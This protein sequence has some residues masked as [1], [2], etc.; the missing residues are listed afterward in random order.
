[1][2]IGG[3]IIRSTLRLSKEL[4]ALEMSLAFIIV[5]QTA[6]LVVATVIIMLV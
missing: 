5:L 6:V 3:T 2:N 4:I 1:M